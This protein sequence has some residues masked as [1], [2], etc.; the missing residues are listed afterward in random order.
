MLTGTLWWL[1]Q[2]RQATGG[3]GQE[4]GDQ[5]GSDRIGPGG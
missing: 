5:S 2:G 4:L 1:L 3:P